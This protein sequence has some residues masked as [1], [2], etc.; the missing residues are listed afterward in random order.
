MLEKVREKMK[1]FMVKIRYRKKGKLLRL[2][3]KKIE[4]NC[5][6]K[7]IVLKNSKNIIRSD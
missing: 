6:R 3:H 2:L 5:L 4:N 7:A 1:I